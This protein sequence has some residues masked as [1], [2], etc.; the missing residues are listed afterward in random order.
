MRTD[1]FTET[2]MFL[3]GQQPDQQTL[4]I[5]GYALTLLFWALLLGSVV[6]A[7]RN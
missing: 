7:I 4:G 5:F 1:P 6:I 2:V 3:L